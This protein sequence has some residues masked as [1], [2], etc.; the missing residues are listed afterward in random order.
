M[1]SHL[2]RFSLGQAWHPKDVV[3]HG[4]NSTRYPIGHDTQPDAPSSIGWAPQCLDATL[5]VSWLK[6]AH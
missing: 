6:L 4:M 2:P 1:F 3:W 5:P